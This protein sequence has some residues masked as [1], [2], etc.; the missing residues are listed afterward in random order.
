VGAVLGAGAAKLADRW[1][2]RRGDPQPR[3]WLVRPSR[4]EGDVDWQTHIPVQG[5]VELLPAPGQG[6]W[7]VRVLNARGQL[8]EEFS[9]ALDFVRLERAPLS[10]SFTTYDFSAHAPPAHRPGTVVTYTYDGSNR[11]T[12]VAEGGCPV[13]SYDY[14]GRPTI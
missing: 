10:S 11:L 12:S 1:L 3:L 8:V 2:P 14:T 5:K 7:T 6:T 13:S 4:K 9:E